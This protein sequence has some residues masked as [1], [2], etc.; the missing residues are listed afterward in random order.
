MLVSVIISA[1]NYDTY[2]ER[3]IRSTLHQSLA[4]EKYEIIV[5]DDASTDSTKEILENY[6]NDIISIHLPKN[7]GLAEARNIGVKKATGQFILFLDADDYIHK[8]L[9]ALQTTFLLENN[10]LDA[11][12]V[13]YYL[14]DEK[15]RH[16]KHV[17]AEED[18]IACGIM[19]RKDR[20]LDIGLYDSSFRA[21]EEEDLRVRFLKKYDIYNIVL[22][23]YRYRQHDDNLTKDPG[24]MKAYKQLLQEKHG[25]SLV[26]KN[27]IFLEGQRINLKSITL[28]DISDRYIAWLNDEEVI[29]GL[30]SPPRPYTKQM[31]TEYIYK[32]MHEE[33]TYML[34]IHERDSKQHLGNIKLH[35][36]NHISRTC[37]LGIMIGEKA[38]WGKGIGSEAC[39]MLIDFAFHH[40]KMRKVW[41]SVHSNNPGAIELYRK[42]GFQ[43]EGKLVKHTLSQGEYVDKVI[44]GIFNKNVA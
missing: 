11:I 21:R 24:E 37:E 23:L 17:S 8:D 4:R 9:L 10:S 27:K 12:S 42:L 29:K 26:N 3:A 38:Y 6:K 16:L 44:M 14:V 36:F 43:E 18:P 2:L 32:M 22:P 39:R 40:L 34:G 28:E 31:L 7:V 1:Y 15:E 41:L 5:V 30:E 33:D 13:D 35:N 19:F 25:L 20:L